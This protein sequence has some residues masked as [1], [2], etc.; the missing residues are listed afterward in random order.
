[1]NHSINPSILDL[2]RFASRG[3]AAQSAVDHAIA[4]ANL[5]RAVSDR[6]RALDAIRLKRDDD[7]TDAYLRLNA[8]EI[9][10]EDFDREAG[11]APA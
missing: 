9:D 11:R 6:Q 5:V 2:A 4:R 10:L 3:A 7:V 1:M 8:A